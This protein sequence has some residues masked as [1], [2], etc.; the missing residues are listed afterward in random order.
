MRLFDL[1]LL[2]LSQVL[3]GPWH[4]VILSCFLLTIERSSI[5]IVIGPVVLFTRPKILIVVFMLTCDRLQLGFL[6][7]MVMS[8]LT[9]S[10]SWLW[11]VMEGRLN[12][13]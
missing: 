6:L 5:V 11:L 10:V 3:E 13:F 7:A 2:F 4:K 8:V 9:A 1:V 12:T